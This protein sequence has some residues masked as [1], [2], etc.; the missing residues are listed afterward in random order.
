[1][2]APATGKALAL[3]SH[4]SRSQAFPPA[5]LMFSPTGWPCPTWAAGLM[6]MQ[7]TCAS[8]GEALGDIQPGTAGGATR[9][10]PGPS[11]VLVP[12]GAGS[13]PRSA[14]T[15]GPALGIDPH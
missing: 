10:S 14:L 3:C 15:H 7:C 8:R 6:G 9:S 2:A 1:M 13:C 4:G 11:M 5:A 12:R